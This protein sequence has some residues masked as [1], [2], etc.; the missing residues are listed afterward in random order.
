MKAPA[1]YSVVIADDDHVPGKVGFHVLYCGSTP[2][3]RTL[4][5]HRVVEALFGYLTSHLD[6]A[7]DHYLVL[8]AM[9]LVHDDRAV[10]LPA[11]VRDAMPR[12]ERRLHGNGVRI[13]DRPFVQLD[14]D[15]AEVVIE[16]PALDIDRHAVAGLYEAIL[17]PRRT[18][19]PVGSGRYRLTGWAFG[20]G[21]G[22]AD[23]ISV[24]EAVSLACLQVVEPVPGGPQHA[25][26]S[27]ARTLQALH[28]TTI[29]AEKPDD[30]VGPLISLMAMTWPQ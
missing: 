15:T 14:A 21:P 7:R 28:R 18:D 29:W 4:D 5:P 9:A 22:R 23:R 20:V 2:V 17:R 26:D 19:Q 8:R 30:L 11:E 3:V 24:G 27:L 12:L 6:S 25:L 1:N 10:L 13:V 16:D